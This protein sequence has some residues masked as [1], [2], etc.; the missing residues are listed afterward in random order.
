MR[1]K[2]NDDPPGYGRL[3][4]AWTPPVS[5]GEA[6]G[7]FATT[8]TFHPSFFETECLGR[9]LQ[10]ES[11]PDANTASYL[12]EREEKMARLM[13]ACVVVDQTHAR[14]SRSL[15]WDLIPFRCATGILHAKISI[16][17]WQH[18]A[19]V[20][21]AS[22]NLTENG[23]RQ[24]LEVFTVWDFHRDGSF[25][26]TLFGEA[27]DFAA[28][29]LAHCR[30]RNPGHSPALERST[31]FLTTARR[32]VSAWMPADSPTA[33]LRTRLVPVT[34]K[35][36]S[37]FAQ[38]TN[39]WPGGSP[40]E[41]LYVLSP[42]F[43][44]GVDN[45]PAREAWSLLRKRGYKEILYSVT[46][47]P[48]NATG[49]L[50]VHA[51]P[52]LVKSLSSASGEAQIH[53]EQIKDLASRPLHAKSLWLE[54]NEHFLHCLGSSNFTTPGLGLGG[55][56]SRNW[57]LNVASWARIDD[58]PEYRS[59]GAAWPLREKQRI[60]PDNVSWDP[61]PAL[62]DEKDPNVA[63]LPEWCGSAVYFVR[64]DGQAT[65]KL[66]LV[67]E[68]PLAWSVSCEG[69]KTPI[70]NA[71]AW[72]TAATP[73]LIELPWSGSRPPTELLVWQ[74]GQKGE[75]RWPVE[76]QAF[77]DLPPPQELRDLTL[78]QLLEILTSALPLH[79]CLRKLRR[80]DRE[81]GAE[82]M[83]VGGLDP[84]QR[85][86]RDTHLLERTRKF[87]LAMAGIRQRLESPIPSE[88]YLQWRL[89][90]PIGIAKVAKAILNEAG[91]K[92]E[93]A[94]LLGEL[95][96]ELSQIKPR[97]EPGCLGSARIQEALRHLITDFEQQAGPL[98]AEAD[99]DMKRYVNAALQKAR[100]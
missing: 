13:S 81:D 9:M 30:L 87:S 45:T 49:K 93:Q 55:E 58:Q 25:P 66:N 65:L 46:T 85:F 74:D 11:D 42:F 77:T 5:A 72:R 62:E 63:L 96:L 70:I 2:K 92:G 34:P 38:L 29:L 52:T 86:S 95:A 99:A 15:R 22:A 91:S 36:Q 28:E 57:E 76:V 60:D 8:F 75:A 35:S 37:V 51:P 56:R 88:E 94:F 43:D 47:E 79:R 10:L 82:S 16:L 98:L 84:L 41:A 100:L 6:L 1:R 18:H 69:E 54:G 23:Y 14:G 21:V 73:R 68:P 80:Q 7:C 48:I 3:L 67:S 12:V 33:R 53:F 97:I 27:A 90:G 59:R 83:P 61:L 89:Y 31:E 39:L 20:I 50:M 71:V 19:R 40:P 64:T 17:L 32:R 78:G 24:N 26:A 4:D 44:Q